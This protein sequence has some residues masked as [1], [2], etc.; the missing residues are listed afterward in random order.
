MLAKAYIRKTNFPDNI[1]ISLNYTLRSI[2]NKPA[3]IQ[4]PL[5]ISP[6]LRQG[7]QN[8]TEWKV[9][10]QSDEERAGLNGVQRTE[11]GGWCGSIA[12][13]R[14]RPEQTPFSESPI[15][16]SH[17]QS[18]AKY[19]ARTDTSTFSDDDIST[20]GSCKQFISGTHLQKPSGPNNRPRRR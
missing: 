17:I 10:F 12:L 6:A 7:L 19:D 11:R 20:V 15:G 5:N 1:K 2:R 18:K 16:I 8:I 13:E 4:A 3:S 14:S 9:D